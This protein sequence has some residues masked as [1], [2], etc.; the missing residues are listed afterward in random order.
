MKN[1]NDN[2]T[3]EFNINKYIENKMIILLFFRFGIEYHVKIYDQMEV[4]LNS[5]RNLS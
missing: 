4:V 5:I 3:G 2:I 1:I